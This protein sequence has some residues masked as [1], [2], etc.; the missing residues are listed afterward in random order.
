M[1]PVCL[2][3]RPH[4]DNQNPDPPEGSDIS[5]LFRG[6]LTQPPER[7]PDREP[8]FWSQAG[9]RRT[10]GPLFRSSPGPVGIVECAEKTRPS[11]AARAPYDVTRRAPPGTLELPL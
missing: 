10:L 5:R 2:A 7:L 4:R 3:V 1:R 9:N 6:H 11:E 8:A